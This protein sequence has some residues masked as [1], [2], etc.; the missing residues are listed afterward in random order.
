[1][2]PGQYNQGYGNQGGRHQG[3][4]EGYGQG[5]YEQHQG[6]YSRPS[7][8]PPGQGYGQGGYGQGGFE[9]NQGGYSRPSGPPPGQSGYSQHSQS[10]GGYSRPSQ[11]PPQNSDGSRLYTSDTSSY[12]S[13]GI[14]YQRPSGSPHGPQTGNGYSNCRGTKKALLVGCNYIG[15]SNAL[16][17][18]INDVHNVYNFL[19]KNGYSADNIVML[20]DDQKES[21]KVP[22]RANILRGMQW[23]VKDARPGD[24]LFFHYSGHGG[25]EKDDDN[26]EDD[27]MDDCIYPVDFQQSG[28]IIDD[29]MND[30]MVQPLQEGVRLTAIFDSCHS[31]TALDLPY[32]YRAQDGGLKEYN[33]WKESKGDAINLVKGYATNNVGLMV[34]SAANVFK[35][36]QTSNSGDKEKIKKENSSPADVIMFSGCKDDQTSADANEAGKFTGALSWAFLQVLNQDPTQTYLTLLQ[37]I[38]TVLATKYTQKPQMSSSHQIDPNIKFVI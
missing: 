17:G 35:R 10:S 27:G 14:T 30:Y 16:R 7:G 36:F 15:T 3:R 25:Q 37:N 34:S 29:V 28:S 6:G 24:S 33:V 32:T 19:L 5:G 38:R 12:Q 4:Q 9:Q 23:L 18:C 2:F 21:V 1:M 31:G 26:D 20:T 13:H 8:P 22:L 11:P